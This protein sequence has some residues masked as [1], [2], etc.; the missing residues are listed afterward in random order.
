MLIG[1]CCWKVLHC[2]CCSMLELHEWPTPKCYR[3]S[4]VQRMPDRHI[5]GQRE[6]HC[7]GV[8]KLWQRQVPGPAEAVGVQVMFCGHAQWRRRKSISMLIAMCCW[9]VLHCR[10]CH[11]FELYEWPTPK[12]YR[13]GHVQRM[14]GRHIHGQREEHCLSVQELWQRRVPRPAEAVGVQVMLCGHAQ[15]RRRKSL[16]MLIAM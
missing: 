16:S 14:P 10:C 11:M 13:P 3:P 9:D 4:H 2:R 6:E 8:Q 5:H 15:W 1:M 12:C 7:L